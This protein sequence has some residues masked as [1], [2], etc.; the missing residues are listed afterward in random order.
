MCNTIHVY[1]RNIGYRAQ[2][3]WAS[4]L[5]GDNTYSF[6]NR[7]TQR[8]RYLKWNEMKTG[9]EHKN[10]HVRL[11]GVTTEWNVSES[12]LAVE[13]SGTKEGLV[14][15]LMFLYV[16]DHHSHHYLYNKHL[17]STWN[18][19]GIAPKAFPYQLIIF[20]KPLQYKCKYHTHFRD[21]EAETKWEQKDF[22]QA[23]YVISHGVGFIH[24]MTSKWTTELMF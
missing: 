16:H 10:T 1:R 2:F 6:C 15:V 19:P 9:E 12:Y 8:D 17:F 22:S 21:E 18:V 20:T 14:H 23:R 24:I 3:L 4:I 7:T 13:F 5:S 11:A